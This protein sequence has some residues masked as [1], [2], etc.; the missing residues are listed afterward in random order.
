[1]KTEKEI[2]ELYLIVNSA[3]VIAAKAKRPIDDI[4]A[5]IS[6]K[7]ALAWILGIEDESTKKLVADMDLLWNSFPEK[8]KEHFRKL[9]HIRLK[10]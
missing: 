2:T 7:D 5:M 4:I 8:T 1:M 6:F 9:G 3:C 10:E